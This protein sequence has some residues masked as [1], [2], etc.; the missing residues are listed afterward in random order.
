M[1]KTF[2]P[3]DIANITTYYLVVEPTDLKNML[4]KLDH[5]SKYGKMKN[6]SKHHLDLKVRYPN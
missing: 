5:L 6:L 4:L 3:V 1:N 2:A